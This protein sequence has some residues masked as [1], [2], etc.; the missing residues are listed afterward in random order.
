MG[1]R[2]DPKRD[3][4]RGKLTTLLQQHDVNPMQDINALFKYMIGSTQLSTYFYPPEIHKAI[5]TTN[6]I[7]NHN[8][9]LRKVTKTRTIFPTDDAL[10]RLLYLAMMDITK[11][12]QDDLQTGA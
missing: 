2:K 6:A 1:S 8:R 3:A 12:G 11:N 7:E 10:F 4:K 9:Q 5:Y